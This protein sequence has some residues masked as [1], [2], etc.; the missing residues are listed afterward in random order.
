MICK[1][2]GLRDYFE[3]NFPQWANA[4]VKY[5]KE[6]QFK[7]TALQDETEEYSNDISDG[8]LILIR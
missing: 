5:S 4:V 6:T 2:E 8:T 1:K 7:C 3:E